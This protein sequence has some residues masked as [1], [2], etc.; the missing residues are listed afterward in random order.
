M[1]F[2]GRSFDPERQ[3]GDNRTELGRRFTVANS[4]GIAMTI[5]NRLALAP[6]ALY[7]AL[8]VF[9]LLVPASQAGMAASAQAALFLLVF[10]Y[11]PAALL[12]HPFDARPG[13]SEA[14]IYFVVGWAG[15]GLSSLFVAAFGGPPF[16]AVVPSLV[17]ILVGMGWAMRS[18]IAAKGPGSQRF[19]LSWSDLGAGVLLVLAACSIYIPVEL[20]MGAGPYPTVFFHGDS[21]YHLGLVRG[22]L[23]DPAFP[24]QSL[25]YAGGFPY[26]HYGPLAMAAVLCRFTGVP[27]HASLFLVLQPMLIAGTAAAAWNFARERRGAIPF[28]AALGLM[29]IAVGHA[30]SQRPPYVDLA[31]GLMAWL[32]GGDGMIANLGN[33]LTVNLHNTTSLFGAFAVTLVILCLS[34]PRRAGREGLAAFM[35]G[36][37]IIFRAPYFLALGAGFGAWSL[38]RAASGRR[39]TPLIAPAAAL[40]I[41]LA[42]YFGVGFGNSGVRLAFD[43]FTLGNLAEIGRRFLRSLTV[44]APGLLVLALSWRRQFP[45][46]AATWLIFAA[47]AMGLLLLFNLYQEDG[48]PEGDNFTQLLNIL[49]A[50]LAAFTIEVLADRWPDLTAG[51]HRITM[52]IL[53]LI[54]APHV[55]RWVWLALL[56][57][58]HPPAGYEYVDNRPLAAAL[59]TIPVQGSLLV[60]NDLRYPANDWKRADRAMQ[61]PALFGHLNFLINP[62]YE[63]H[64]PNLA[65]RRAAIAPLQQ[66][67][68]DPAIL[69]NAKRY[70][71]T[72]FVVHLAYPH[73]AEIPLAL[74]YDSP[75][76]RVYQFPTP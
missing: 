27:A 51:A 28:V 16:L 41:A 44:L 47:A 6:A 39:L 32:R 59:Q 67:V 48:R 34:G 53:A 3:K 5:F 33:A 7:L 49:P 29:L 11:W 19:P 56:V 36:I 12:C 25:S 50:V 46:A 8:A 45:A 61:F 43:P 17:A 60:T 54:V 24:P 26:Y 30:A 4:L 75:D 71:W 18:S 35:T 1:L 68:W 42:I 40:L 57:T 22:L 23:Q 65:E 70:G 10:A 38:W 20:Y 76:Y 37:T 66:A 72:H 58:F 15:L 64:Y 74:I 14:A 52:A 62:T 2:S 55:L 69:D 31:K 9:L 13:L 21:A 63:G 73:P